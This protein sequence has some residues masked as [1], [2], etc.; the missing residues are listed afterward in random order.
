M[1]PFTNKR[2]TGD[3]P[4]NVLKPL[5]GVPVFTVWVE[6]QP[7]GGRVFFLGCLALTKRG[8]PI[9]AGFQKGV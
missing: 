9:R 2:A 3:L 4:M 5:Q 6:N 1:P 8:H 7:L